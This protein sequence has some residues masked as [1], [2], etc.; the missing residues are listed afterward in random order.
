MLAGLG[1]P[2]RAAT[3][4]HYRSL[5]LDL[6]PGTGHLAACVPGAFDAWLLL[7]ER[8]GTLSLPDV[9]APAT[10]YARRGYPVIPAIARTIT[11][12]EQLFTEHWPTSAAVYLPGGAVPEPG[13][14]LTNSVLA[15]TYERLSA[16][17]A[18]KERVAG[19]AAARAAFYRGFVAQAVDEFVRT[20]VMDTSG[21]PHAGVLTADDLARWQTP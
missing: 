18:G 6:V 12:V 4:E 19:I 20:P 1:R 10:G 17:A 13:S 2:P 15:D 11:A 7:L 3:I 21:T 8:Y 5:G 9:L 14:R 16:L